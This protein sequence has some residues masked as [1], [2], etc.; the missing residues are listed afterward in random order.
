MAEAGAERVVV[1]RIGTERFALPVASVRAVVALPAVAR[2]PGA[3]TTVRGL[4]NVR[5]TLV[6][7]VSGARL[8]GSS[9]GTAAAEWL[10]VLAMLG[11][12][13]GLEVDEV[14]DLH[15][16]G[17]AGEVPTLDLEALIRPLFGQPSGT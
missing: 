2:I 15:T 17:S 4:V 10:V 6:T 13:V 9:E 1:C 7:T 3:P 11:G 12:R 8:L 5:G 14:E 16:T